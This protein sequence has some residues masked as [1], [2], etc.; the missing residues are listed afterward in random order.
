L[1][2]YYES[3]G[4]TLYLGDCREV[5][6]KLDL[7][8]AIITDPPYELGF[9]GKAWDKTGIANDVKMWSECLRVLRPGGHLLSFGG[10]RT[11]HRMACAIEDAGFEIRDQIMWIYGCL[12]EQTELVSESGVKPYHKAKIGERVLCYNLE[13]GEY[14]YQPISE[15]VEYDYSDTAYRLIGDFGEQVVSRNHRCIVERDGSEVFQFAEALEPEICVPVLESLPKLQQALSDLQPLPSGTQQSVR[16][17]MCK[18]SNIKRPQREDKPSFGEERES[19]SLRGLRGREVDAFISFEE[20]REAYMQPRVQRCSQGSRVE[21]TRLQRAATVDAGIGIC[22]EDSDDWRNQSGMEGRVDLSKA[23]GGVCRPADQV[24]SLPV[25]VPEHGAEGWLCD[26]TPSVGS[27]SYGQATPESG[28]GASQESSCNG[29]SSDQL[30]AVFDKRGTQGTRGWRGHKTAVVRVVPFQYTGKMW[31]LRVPTGAFVAVRGGVAFPTGNSGFPKSLDVS[32]AID[33]AAR[34]VPQGAADPTSP[35]HGQFKSGCSE[36]NP[37]G[38]GFGAGP[39]QFMRKDGREVIGR[40]KHP[41]LKDTSLIEESA[42]AAHGSNT[43]AR[44]WDITAPATEAAKEWSG[45]GTALKPA[46]EPICVARKPIEGTVAA[47]VLKHGTGALNIDGCRVE[48]EESTVRDNP[49][50]KNRDGWG[51]GKLANVAGSLSGRWP[52]NVCHDGSDEVVSLFPQSSITGDRSSQS[53][54]A[55]VAGTNWL[56]ENHESTEYTDS[57]SAARFFYCAKADREERSRGM[58]GG[59]AVI[60]LIG[61]E[62]LK[63]NPM[64]GKGTVDIPRANTHPTVKPL[65]LMAYL[66]KLLCPPSGGVLLD[67]FMGSGT[68]IIAGR[69][70]YQHCIGIELEEKYAEIAAKRL[71]QEVL[72]FGGTE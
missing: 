32:K 68:T 26:G 8:H 19:D 62:R 52:A 48:G 57:G 1:K 25:R 27:S 14:S 51:M 35:N 28:S 60:T 33:K 63:I 72:D 36:D 47:N 42:N 12:D 5:M 30:D 29:K 41:T 61:Q 43:W 24:C 9:M 37:S 67:P 53:K 55:P 23:Q 18:S 50:R 16:Q 71:S 13:N 39:G 22:V 10:S 6:P 70:F 4:V 46:H 65:D 34:G 20:N 31:C 3:N 17:C 7:V 15:I 66:C 45:Y 56:L 40:R 69:R 59:E 11:Y 21:A 2:P 44:E 49:P 54:S 38:R 58:V 64:T